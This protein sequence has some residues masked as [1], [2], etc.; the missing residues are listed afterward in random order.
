[1]KGVLLRPVVLEQELDNYIFI[2]L[3]PTSSKQ[4]LRQPDR[5]AQNKNNKQGNWGKMKK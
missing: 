2:I 1:M 4:D 3:S 5:D